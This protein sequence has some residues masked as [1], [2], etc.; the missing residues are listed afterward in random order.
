M[1]NSDIGSS[2]FLIGL[3]GFMAWQAQK[4]TVGTFRS[5]GPGFFP[6][7]LALLVIGI[8]TIIFFLGL[9]QKPAERETGLRRERV[10]LAL[11]AVFAYAIFL[12]SLGYLLSTFFLMI[13]L[14]K[15]MSKKAWWYS[16]GLAALIALGSYL[17]FR[18]SLQLSLPR[19][20][21]GF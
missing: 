4:I 21:L 11:A 2:L 10:V 14:L 15:L 20:I 9:K 13:L 7:C 16:P 5:P 8:A 1:K 6:F 18:V 17:L 3:G 19:G 12:E